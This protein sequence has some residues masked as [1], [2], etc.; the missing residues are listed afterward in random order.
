MLIVDIIRR[1]SKVTHKT[2]DCI[3]MC[4]QK[5]FNH[6]RM[7]IEECRA[8]DDFG[9]NELAI[10]PEGALINEACPTILYHEACCI[11]LGYPGC[12]N[13]PLLEQGQSCRVICGHDLYCSALVLWFQAVLL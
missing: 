13:L 12:V 3:N 2:L 5:L 10:R 8:H 9:S 1:V 11:R 4:L 7:L 6:I